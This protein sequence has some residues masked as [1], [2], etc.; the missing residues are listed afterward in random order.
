MMLLLI[1]TSRLGIRPKDVHIAKKWRKPIERLR[2]NLDKRR[3]DLKAVKSFSFRY[4]SIKMCK[5]T[6][7]YLRSC[8]N[9]ERFHGYQFQRLAIKR[10][11]T[12][13]ASLKASRSLI[14]IRS[15]QLEKWL[16]ILTKYLEQTFKSSFQ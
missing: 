15:H 1:S 2:N 4:I 6:G 9:T 5:T 3:L 16:M 7:L 10:T 13:Q 14:Q 11:N 8:T 12:K